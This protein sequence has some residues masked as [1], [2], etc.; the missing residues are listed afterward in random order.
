MRLVICLWCIDLL[1]LTQTSF[2][3]LSGMDTWMRAE[4]GIFSGKTLREVI[5]LSLCFKINLI[6]PGSRGLED[7]CRHLMPVTLEGHVCHPVLVPAV[8][9]L[10]VSARCELP[11]YQGG[12]SAEI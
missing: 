10:S 1:A 2:L 11:R 8:R 7:E 4:A 5:Y 6:I 9:V 3:A 12:S